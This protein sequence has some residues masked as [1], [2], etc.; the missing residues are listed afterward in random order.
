[1][2]KTL[3]ELR[4]ALLEKTRRMS[5]ILDG[6]DT[7]KRDLS[8]DENAEFRTLTAARSDLEAQIADKAAQEEFRAARAATVGTGTMGNRDTSAGDQRD[9]EG[10]NLSKA[11][12]DYSEGR[13]L[14]GVEAEANQEG[15]KSARENGAPSNGLVFPT[16]MIGMRGQTVTGQAANPGDQGGVTVPK[17]MQG[18]IPN[19]WSK[20]FLDKVGANRVSGLKGDAVFPKI[21]TKPSIQERTENQQLDNDEILF[22]SFEM[23]PERRGTKIPISKLLL[24]QSSIDARSEVLSAINKALGIKLNTEAFAKVNSV[25]T[26]GNGNLLALDTNG[27]YISWEDVVDLEGFLAAKDADE[28]LPKY[29]TNPK[30]KTLLKTTQKFTGTNGQPVWGETSELNGYP[31]YT[32]NIVPANL[33]KGSTNTCSAMILGNWQDLY[34]GFWDTLDLTIDTVTLADKFQIQVIV[35]ALWDVEVA[36]YE[37]FAGI[38]DAKTI[39]A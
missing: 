7:E 3:K 31:A 25:I 39:R 9:I 19:L 36:R 26:S 32:S 2:K 5:E 22:S 21:I 37:S 27:D 4:D 23:K 10:F 29:L 20:T 33:V 14:T 24:R 30:I 1:M 8:E 11:L 35:N 12:L 13:Q 18:L 34:V 6:A 17:E 15:I 38:K 16:Y 28:V